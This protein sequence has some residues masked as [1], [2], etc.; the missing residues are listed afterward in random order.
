MNTTETSDCISER[1]GNNLEKWESNWERK[2][3]IWENLVNMTGMMVSSFSRGY[4]LETRENR[5][6]KMENMMEMKGCS[7][8]KLV[9]RKV[10][11]DYMM[12]MLENKR[13]RL[14]SM[15]E[16]WVNRREKLDCKMAKW[17]YKT[18]M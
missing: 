10:M 1:L 11:L 12:G 16:R 3:S 13:E 4:N 9:S 8:A 2:A 7:L 14:V 17:D 6:V 15:R 18:E 5:R